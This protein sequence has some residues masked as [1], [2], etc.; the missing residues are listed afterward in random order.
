MDTPHVSTWLKTEITVK[1]KSQLK[2]S[3]NN[4]LAI[5][6]RQYTGLRMKLLSRKTWTTNTSTRC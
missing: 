5:I 3:S 1:L 6:K 4:S 2:F